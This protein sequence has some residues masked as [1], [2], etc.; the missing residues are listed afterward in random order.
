[1]LSDWERRLW[2]AQVRALAFEYSSSHRRLQPRIYAWRCLAPEPTG[3]KRIDELDEECLQLRVADTICM[4]MGENAMWLYT[5]KAGFV[6]RYVYCSSFS[7]CFLRIRQY[8][9][10]IVLMQC[11]QP[12]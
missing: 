10:A 4:N 9:C 2:D 7:N 1:M 8:L 12:R 5:N 3:V 6:H 11:L